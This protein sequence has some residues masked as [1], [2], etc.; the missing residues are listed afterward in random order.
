MSA[1]GPAAQRTP[2]A[3]APDWPPPASTRSRRAVALRLL[4]AGLLLA[5]ELPVLVPMAVGA[6]V[7]GAIDRCAR[8]LR[9]LRGR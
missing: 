4:F 6:A 7:T 5:L 2:A 1:A 8:A 9:R 3:P